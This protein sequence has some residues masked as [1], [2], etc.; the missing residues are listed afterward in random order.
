MKNYLYEA[1]VTVKT[2][3]SSF[4]DFPHGLRIQSPN[5][6]E[7]LD[8]LE[9]FLGRFQDVE[10]YRVIEIKEVTEKWE[11]GGEKGATSND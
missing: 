8:K 7:A 11:A 2:R 5:I 10:E 1:K 9:E 4:E 3:G 6:K